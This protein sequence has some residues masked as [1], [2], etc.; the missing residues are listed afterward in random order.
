[1]RRPQCFL[2]SSLLLLSG[3]AS[4]AAQS[5]SQKPAPIVHTYSIVARDPVTGDMGVA[6]QSHAFSVGSIVLWGEAGVGVVATQSL[7]D[8]GYGPKG[9]E[10]MRKGAAEAL[11]HSSRWTLSRRVV[12]SPC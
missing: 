8:P 9:L 12:K 5:A 10:L 3:T 1:M 6:V 11:K 4:V 2:F 7:V